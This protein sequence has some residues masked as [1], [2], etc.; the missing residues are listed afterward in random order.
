M[1]FMFQCSSR[2]IR[3]AL[4]KLLLFLHLTVLDLELCRCSRVVMIDFCILDVRFCDHFW[5]VLLFFNARILR[6]IPFPVEDD[7]SILEFDSL[8]RILLDTH[9]WDVMLS[10]RRNPV[11][12]F[13]S[14]PA[15]RE[16]WAAPIGLPGQDAFVYRGWEDQGDGSLRG[17]PRSRS[18]RRLA[19]RRGRRAR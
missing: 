16:G 9:A 1:S 6:F 19:S 3:S 11:A 5:G 14:R 15:F 4:R 17:L 18:T 7:G 2:V 13:L 12:V 10:S 8:E